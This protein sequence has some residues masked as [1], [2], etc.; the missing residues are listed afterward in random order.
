MGDRRGKQD[1]SVYQRKDGRWV[2]SISIDGR[3]YYRYGQSVWDALEQLEAIKKEACPT[4]DRPASRITLGEWINRW[5][6][7]ISPDIRPSTRNTYRYTLTPISDEIGHVHLNE[8]SSLLLTETFTRIRERGKGARQLNL[9]HGYLKACLKHAVNLEI[10][11]KDPMDKVRRPK[12]TQ[13]ERVYWDLEEVKRFIRTG[14]GGERYWDALFVF[15]CVSGLRVSEALAL[16]WDDVAPNDRM[17][18]VERAIVWRGSH[19]D[20]VEPK[21]KA[22]IRKVRIPA[23]ARVALDV[24]RLRNISNPGDRIFTTKNGTPPRLSDLAKSLKSLCNRAEVR[25]MNVHG[26]R[27]VAAM[28]ALEAVDD[29]Y[30]VQKRLG[31][32]HIS[33]TLGIYGYSSK[34]ES[35]V[36]SQMDSLLDSDSDS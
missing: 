10:I 3:R 16:Q 26:L 9:A 20:E 36:G 1:G 2:A 19:Y 34:N 21:T 33:V 11:D 24:V 17:V 23:V 29:P 35:E 12:W 25:R 14:L 4:N 5:L 13:R 32:S 18:K 22:G 6:A 28:L 30:L 8:L 31:H 15:L 27:H 7:E